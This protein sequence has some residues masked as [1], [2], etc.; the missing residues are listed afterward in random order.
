MTNK[1]KEIKDKLQSE[2]NKILK[3]YT[4]KRKEKWIDNILKYFSNI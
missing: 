2:Q 1:L 4:L 3:N